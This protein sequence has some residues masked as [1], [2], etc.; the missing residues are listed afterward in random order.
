VDRHGFDALSLV[1]GAVLVGIG[2]L[3]VAGVGEVVV[4]GSW[5]GPI[6]AIFIGILLVVAAPRPARRTRNTS[7]GEEVADAD[8]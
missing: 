2:V 7:S 5:I 1:F 6:V 3:L 8:A 4:T